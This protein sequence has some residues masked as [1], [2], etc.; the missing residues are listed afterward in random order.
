MAQEEV[1]DRRRYLPSCYL[2][3]YL[4]SIARISLEDLFTT[5]FLE[6]LAHSLVLH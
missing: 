6:Y 2:R 5:S 3:L 4:D 1:V